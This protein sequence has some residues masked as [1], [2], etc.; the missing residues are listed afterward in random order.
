MAQYCYFILFLLLLPEFVIFPAA[1]GLW[2][3]K[4]NNN[5]VHEEIKIL[6]AAENQKLFQNLVDELALALWEEPACTEKFRKHTDRLTMADP[7]YFKSSGELQLHFLAATTDTNCIKYDQRQSLVNL[8]DKLAPSKL[9]K[10]QKNWSEFFKFIK[11]KFVTP[12]PNCCNV[13]DGMRK[14]IG[15][16]SG[17][18][19]L[20]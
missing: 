13:Q 8:Y 10:K 14:T 2:K 19:F 11:D 17:F 20:S 1:L 16:K 6:A 12:I 3:L 9:T 7:Y 4:S 15:N 5:S 18:F